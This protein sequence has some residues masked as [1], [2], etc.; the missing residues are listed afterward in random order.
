MT[1]RTASA[2]SLEHFKGVRYLSGEISGAVLVVHCGF[3]QPVP[4]IR[5]DLLILL[6]VI[7]RGSRE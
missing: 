6:H 2:L 5:L 1:R 7:P 4:Q 3:M